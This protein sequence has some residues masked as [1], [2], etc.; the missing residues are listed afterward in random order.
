MIELLALNPN[1]SQEQLLD[2]TREGLLAR[3]RCLEVFRRGVEDMPAEYRVQTIVELLPQVL[4]LV[5]ML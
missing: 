2:L 4:T 3:A 1:L 5:M